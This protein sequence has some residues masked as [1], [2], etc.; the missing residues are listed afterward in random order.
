[1]E[2][3]TH[4]LLLYGYWLIFGWVLV[5]LLG[6]PI[7]VT[8][9]L[10]AAGALSRDGDMNLGLSFAAAVSGA[11][12]A[13]STWYWVGRRYG[14][15][16]LKFLC[17]ILLEPTNCVR[18][19]QGTFG[20][21][22]GVTLLYAKFIPGLSTLVA[23]IAGQRRMDYKRF[24]MFDTVGAIFW[25]G[26]LLISGRLFG[27]L[28]A[29][30]PHIFDWVGRFSGSLLLIGILGF[31]AIR[32]IR[33][34]RLLKALAAA[35]LDPLELKQ[36]LDAGEEVF[37]VDLRHPDERIEDAFTLPG[38]HLIL[39]HEIPSRHETIPRDRDVI[40]FC[41]C[42]GEAAAAKVALS[43]H[44]QGVERVRPLRGG[45]GEWKRLGFPLEAV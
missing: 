4:I 11:L 9:V 27:D 17:K 2:L 24:L 8:P 36:M 15:Q 25:I 39:P 45:Y 35:R 32:V 13:D 30:N 29:K 20:Q 43:L 38:A 41:S 5:D 6:L 19:S 1:M 23:P 37:I 42:P 33:R 34:Q 26:T 44:K 31:F 22:H 16:V 12:V 28:L 21:H 14:A 18:K 3:P 7:P 10:L 40:V